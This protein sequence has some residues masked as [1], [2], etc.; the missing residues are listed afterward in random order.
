MNSRTSFYERTSLGSYVILVGRLVSFS[1]SKVSAS[2]E[3]AELFISSDCHS[4][5]LGMWYIF[6]FLDSLKISSRVGNL[7]PEGKNLG[8]GVVYNN[9]GESFKCTLDS[10]FH[11]VSVIPF[12]IWRNIQFFRKKI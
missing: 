2:L 1:E 10:S 6:S 4:T 12:A 9:L 11:Q 8:G 7:L 5:S 3:R